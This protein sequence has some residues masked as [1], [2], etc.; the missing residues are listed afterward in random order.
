MHY[1]VTNPVGMFVFDEKNKLVKFIYLGDNPE[2]TARKMHK[3]EKNEELPEMQQL[4]SEFPDLV[5]SQ[6]NPATEFLRDNFRRIVLERGIFKGESELNQYINSVMIAKS[7]LSISKIERRDKMIIQAVNALSDIERIVNTI[8]E[9]IREWYGLHYPELI[10]NDHEKYAAMIVEF[11][12]RKNFNDFRNSMGMEL[13]DEDIKI[14]QE[15]AKMYKE[16]SVVRKDLD[17]YIE[18][19]VK[20]EMPNINA[21][22]GSTLAARLLGL[23]GSLEKMA[24]M[25]SSSI[26]LL[27]AEKSLFKFMK[28]R[29]KARPPRF[30]IL[31]LHP[32]ISTNRRDLQGKIARVLS[33]KLTL[34]ARADFY[35]KSDI[36]KDLLADY[37][38]RVEEILKQPAPA[39][40]PEKENPYVSFKENTQKDERRGRQ[41]RSFNRNERF[42]PNK[43]R[44]RF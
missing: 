41:E 5:T 30:G 12:D 23:A 15:Y 39:P 6:P 14:I 42:S 7:R 34:A 32:D 40:T 1:L 4:K 10:I 33:S 31:Y 35:S 22:L 28:G 17:K 19:T 20:E 26:Q 2:E 38:K 36:S 25:P 13:R 8:I 43:K 29:E 3:A 18:K 21:L 44:P 24:K 11:G 16:M 37:K 27:G 9:R